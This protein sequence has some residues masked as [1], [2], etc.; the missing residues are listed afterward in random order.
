VYLSQLYLN[1]GEYEKLQKWNEPLLTQEKTNDNYD[2]HIYTGEAYYRQKNYRPAV[3]FFSAGIALGARKPDAETLFKLGHSY[4]ETGEKQ[5]AIDQLKLS[6]L[7]E[8]ATGQASAFQLGTIYTEMGQYANALHAYEIAGSSAHDK[9]ITEEAQFLAGKL[10]VRL[11]QYSQ[12]ITKLEAFIKIYPQSARMSEANELLSTAYLNTS[13]YDLVISHFERSTV[14]SEQL[15]KNYQKV[16]LIKGMQLFSDRQVQA[17]IGLLTKSVN[18]P[19]STALQVDGYYWLGECYFTMGD[20]AQ[21]RTA[22][23]KAKSLDGAHTL[24]DYGLGYLAYNEKQYADAKASFQTFLRKDKTSAFRSDAAMRSADCDYAL[25]NYDAALAGYNSLIGSGVAQDYLHFQIG[26]IHQLNGRTDQAVAAYRKVVVMPKSTLRDNALFQVGQSYFEV[27]NFNEAK[28]AFTSYMDQFP[29]EPT[30]VI[31]RAKRAQ[32]HFNQGNMAGAKADY[33]Y[34]LDNHIAHPVAQDALL[35]IQELQKQG[36]NINFDK[37]MAAYRAAH[38]EDSSLETIEFEQAKNLYFAQNYQG[39]IEKLELLLS[40]NKQ[41]PFKEDMIY[42]LG[43]SY[44]RVGNNTAS[45]QYFEQIVAMPSSTYLNRV[46]EKRGRLLLETGQGTKAVENYNLL[47]QNSKSRKE[48]YL[49]TEGLMKA[50]FIL[51]QPDKT[52]ENARAI[53]TAEWKPSNAE[54]QAYLYIGKALMAKQDNANATDEFLKVI[55]GSTDELAAEAK[56]RIGEIQYKQGKHQQSLESLFQLNSAY[57]AYQQW[58][59]QS[60][61]LIA[62]NYI[63]MNELLQAKATLNSLVDNFKDEKI[64]TEARAKLATIDQLQQQQV[65]KDTLR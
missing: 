17:A 65:A 4:Y 40:K 16:T 46:L 51:N 53:L 13:N 62:D 6:G 28:T 25:K 29:N 11:E 2:L 37:Y 47:I 58:I 18:T 32:A 57:G 55:N 49:G 14:K 59:G 41:S 20:A 9:A 50:Y 30:A 19:V 64:K 36:E 43:D 48:S 35:G 7:N 15:K 21:A 33:L 22:Y 54:N 5:K 63:K 27:A 12:A 34:V 26:L 42:Y 39:A 38:P 23:Q 61:L 45:N 10:S 52:I 3:R 1:A 24:S 60:F 56:Y 31:A 8:T 44:Q